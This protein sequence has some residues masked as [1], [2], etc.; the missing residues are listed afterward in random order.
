MAEKIFDSKEFK[1]A[2]V[3]YYSETHDENNWIAACTVCSWIGC[4]RDTDTIKRTETLEYWE[5]GEYES[6]Y[7]THHCP[8]CEDIVFDP[9]ETVNDPCYEFNTVD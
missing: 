1:Q 8:D 2:E 5:G 9:K 7:Y 6:E 3:D 4:S